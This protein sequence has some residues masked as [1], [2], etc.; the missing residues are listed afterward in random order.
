MRGPFGGRSFQ[1]WWRGSVFQM[2]YCLA[3]APWQSF[4]ELG[5][6]QCAF[7]HAQ[8]SR[9]SWWGGKHSSSFILL[10]FLVLIML[11]L[12]IICSPNDAQNIGTPIVPSQLFLAQ[13]RDWWPSTRL[14]II[15]SQ[16]RSTFLEPNS[17]ASEKAWFKLIWQLY[18]MLENGAIWL[19]KD[20]VVPRFFP[21]CR[22]K[23]PAFQEIGRDSS[24]SLWPWPVFFRDGRG[25]PF[26]KEELP[27][28]W[29]NMV[30]SNQS[31]KWTRSTLKNMGRFRLQGHECDTTLRLSLW[32]LWLCYS[33]AAMLSCRFIKIWR[34]I[35]EK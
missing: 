24:F 22:T 1:R 7:K 31:S 20:W 34:F 6:N 13:E 3:G 5:E 30:K 4:I 21:W 23:I 19:G 16:A 27:L 12:V 28:L 35:Y 29:L 26:L 11:G 25:Y 8:V 33:G 18:I 17:S 15:E 10:D 2:K 14:S 32:L 9:K